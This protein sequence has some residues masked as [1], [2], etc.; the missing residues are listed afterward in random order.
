MM[1]YPQF[2]YTAC[3]TAAS[4]LASSQ[5][6]IFI[7][8]CIYLHVEIRP[9]CWGRIHCVM[10]QSSVYNTVLTVMLIGCLISFLTSTRYKD[11]LR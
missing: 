8:I 5:V 10:E 6:F 3:P 4:S 2:G 1:A 9:F 7:F 11:I